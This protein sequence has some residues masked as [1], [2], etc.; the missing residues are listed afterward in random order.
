[1][2][3][4]DV[5]VLHIS[6]CSTSFG[7]AGATDRADAGDPRPAQCAGLAARRAA[8]S[9]AWAAGAL[10]Q[11]GEDWSWS[12]EEMGKWEKWKKW[13]KWYDSDMTWDFS[14]SQITL[15]KWDQWDQWDQ[16]HWT[17]GNSEETPMFFIIRGIKSHC[18][19]IATVPM[20]SLGSQLLPEAAGPNNT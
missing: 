1:M 4:I 7:F 19:N 17:L 6:S 9:L 18:S 8:P 14:W 12:H 2:L 16:I 11:A 15:R 20:C 5:H 13:K 3:D 10:G